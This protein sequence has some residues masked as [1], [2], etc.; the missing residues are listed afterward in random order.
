MTIST[1]SAPVSMASNAAFQAWVSE[2]ISNLV[3]TCGLTQTTDTG[4]IN[5]STVTIPTA[6]DTSAGYVILRFNDALQTA[7]PTSPNTT[8]SVF[9]KLEFGTGAN[10]VTNPNMWITV[11]TGSD[12]AGTLTGVVGTRMTICQNTSSL[13]STTT[14]YKSYYMYNST[15]GVAGMV[16]KVGAASINGNAITQSY[17]GFYIFRSNDSSGNPTGDSINV[18]ALNGTYSTGDVFMNCISFISGLTY[19]GTIWSILPL[20]AA[21]VSGYTSNYNGNTQVFP[22][23]YQ[24]PYYSISAFGAIGSTFD[25]SVGGTFTM[26]LM[27][28]TSHTFLSAGQMFGSYYVNNS[29]TGDSSNQNSFLMIWE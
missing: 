8:A 11:G 29:S 19:I 4:Q 24:T 14:S 27:G 5:T 6:Q 26:T 10:S 9:V 15:L 22:I 12:G 25:F 16:F 3:T 1:T 18:I 13:A 2:V 7:T 21:G 28:S 23:F 17:G 20:S